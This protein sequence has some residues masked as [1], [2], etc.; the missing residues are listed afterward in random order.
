[1]ITPERWRQLEPLLDRVLDAAP[2]EQAST[3]RDACGDDAEMRRQLE[4]MVAECAGGGTRQALDTPAPERFSR[5]I[6]DEL[7]ERREPPSLVADR[8]RIVRALGQGGMS[9]I[10]LAEDTRHRRRVALKVLTPML[11]AA[12]ARERFLAEIQIAASLA[13]PHI[14]ALHDSGESDGLL[15]YVMPFIEGESLRERL[16]RETR[17]PVEQTVRIATEVADALTFAHA[18]HIVHRDMKPEN[19]LFEAGHAVICDFGIARAVQM[20]SEDRLTDTGVLI[21]TPSYMSPEQAAG[22]R[23]IDP[24]SDIYSLACVVYEMLT[25]SPPYTGKA[26]RNVIVQHLTAPI[27]SLRGFRPDAPP[28]LERAIVTALAKSPARRFSTAAQFAAAMT[29]PEEPDPP[30]H[31]WARWTA[32]LRRRWR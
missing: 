31:T 22:E 4:E 21:G 5:L 23:A 24:R 14:V 16:S 13:H 17:L 28:A 9:S 10:Y 25:G 15:Y 6:S 27:P 20:S 2:D 12:L 26:P 32:G 11:S 18:R 8:Y 3:L 1:M 30:A 29:A 19:I 7:A